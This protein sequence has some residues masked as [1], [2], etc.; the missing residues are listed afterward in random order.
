MCLFI[1]TLIDK[2]NREINTYFC[3]KFKYI[4]KNTLNTT[5]NGTLIQNLK[6]SITFCVMLLFIDTLI[7]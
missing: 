3:N 5:S 2:L 7:N 4:Q 6:V 1:D